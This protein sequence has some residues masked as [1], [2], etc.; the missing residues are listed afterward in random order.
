LA[1]HQLKGA[2]KCRKSCDLQ[3]ELSEESLVAS[4]QELV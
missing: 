4:K 3:R 2:L 1:G